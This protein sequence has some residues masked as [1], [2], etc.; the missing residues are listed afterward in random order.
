M[1]SCLRTP[2]LEYTE[3]AL[4]NI[5][6][7]VGITFS[8]VT[9]VKE[10]RRAP[11]PHLRTKILFNTHNFGGLRAHA[12]SFPRNLKKKTYYIIHAPTFPNS[13]RFIALTREIPEA[14]FTALPPPATGV[15]Y[16]IIIHSKRDKSPLTVGEF[17]KLKLLRAMCHSRRR[18]GCVFAWGGDY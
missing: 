3:G 10:I 11:P 17:P 6:F 13:L 14:Y 9:P 18:V 1:W 15:R 8:I 12:M 16:Y 4:V 2:S 5:Y 7:W